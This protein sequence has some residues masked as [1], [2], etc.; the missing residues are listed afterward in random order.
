MDLNWI[1]TVVVAI[2]AASP[3]IYA[4]LAN[5]HKTTADATVA[6]GSAYRALFDELQERIDAQDR[7][8]KDLEAAIEAKNQLIDAQT[9]RIN[10][11]EAEVDELRAIMR[12]H[13]ITPPP[14]RR[15]RKDG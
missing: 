3:G 14:R 10:D 9:E 13:K 12:E 8:I 6:I 11:L 2:I 1:T 5:R 7:R 4:I 15:P